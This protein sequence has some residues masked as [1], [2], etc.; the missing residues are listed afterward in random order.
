M[1]TLYKLQR[2]VISLP[3][4]GVYDGKIKFVNLKA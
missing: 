1:D 2:F 3:K 4:T